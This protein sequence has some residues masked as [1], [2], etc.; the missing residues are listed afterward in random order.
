MYT[1]RFFS[2]AEAQNMLP[3]LRAMLILAKDELAGLRTKVQEASSNYERCEMALGS[4]GADDNKADELRQLR[5]CRRNFQDAIEELSNAQHDYVECLN[6]WIE[7]ISEKGVLLRDIRTG[8]LDFPA[9]RGQ[10]EYFLCWR[11]EEET[12]NFWHLANDG[13]I[14]RRPLAVLAEYI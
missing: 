6:A 7:R 9:K 10:F 12:I 4:I 2:L 11:Q 3:E 8:L 5:T 14:G 1:P 13:F